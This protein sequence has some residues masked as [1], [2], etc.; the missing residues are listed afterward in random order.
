VPLSGADGLERDAATEQR[1]RE[2]RSGAVSAGAALCAE[3]CG[4]AAEV[5][6]T[7]C[8]TPPPLCKECFAVAHKSKTMQSHHQQ[9]LGAAC[10]LATNCP[11]HPAYPL[12][13]VCL[14]AACRQPVCAKCTLDAHKGHNCAA[15]SAAAAPIGAEIDRL[16]TAVRTALPQLEKLAE[17]LSQRAGSIRA[18]CQS[19]R[20]DV[21]AQFR[22][23]FTELEALRDR[24]LQSVDAAEASVLARSTG[25]QEALSSA[26]ALVSE[27]EAASRLPVSGQLR[28]E[29]SLRDTESLVRSVKTGVDATAPSIALDV[30][31]VV[32]KARESLVLRLPRSSGAARY[33]RRCKRAQPGSRRLGGPRRRYRSYCVHATSGQVFTIILAGD[34]LI[35]ADP[36]LV[37]DLQR[38]MGGAAPKKLSLLYRGS[39][40]GLHTE[41]FHA[42]CDGRGA[43]LT[44]VRSK[45]GNVFGGYASLPWANSGGYKQDASAY[46]FSLR[47][48]SAPAGAPLRANSRGGEKQGVYHHADNVIFEGGEDLRIH[49][50][51]QAGTHYTYAKLGVGYALVSARVRAIHA[52]SSIRA[53]AGARLWRGRDARPRHAGRREGVQRGRDRSVQRGVNRLPRCPRTRAGQ[54]N[55]G[56]MPYSKARVMQC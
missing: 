43:T 52:P 31:G 51:M 33:V 42:K 28:Y 15:D 1:V 10:K 38:V 55:A 20:G 41:K 3:E 54:T 5:L 46:I 45:K 14:D 24:V 6:C 50:N 19:V 37:A 12:D 47:G 39:R 7:H 9:P 34:S 26:R 35:L 48:P 27:R 23:L 8:V 30:E 18:Q 40:D 4:R 44:V 32:R 11:S 25:G 56:H 21:L 49:T 2:L 29:A 22:R 17:E 13:A 53:G 16:L 36:A